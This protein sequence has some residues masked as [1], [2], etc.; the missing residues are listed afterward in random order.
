MFAR[1]P[2]DKVT[3]LVMIVRCLRESCIAE[4]CLV[5]IGDGSNNSK[6]IV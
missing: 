5:C 6:I 4:S 2:Q 3:R 1:V